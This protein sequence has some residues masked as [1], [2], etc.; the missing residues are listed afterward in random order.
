MP[1]VIFGDIT[2]P[3]NPI[4]GIKSGWLAKSKYTN[5]VIITFY[6][7]YKKQLVIYEMVKLTI[8]KVCVCI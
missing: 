4:R 8:I 2:S 5:Y 1:Q 7:L 6:N 3:Q